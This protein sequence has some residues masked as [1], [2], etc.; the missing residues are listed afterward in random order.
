MEWVVESYCEIAMGTKADIV[1]NEAIAML[2]DTATRPDVIRLLA[3][4]RG[5]ECGR[6]SPMPEPDIMAGQCSL[7][8]RGEG[9]SVIIFRA[10]PARLGVDVLRFATAT[11]GVPLVSD[12]TLAEARLQLWRG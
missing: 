6:G 9:D 5:L 11:T 7:K 1:E 10:E 2:R 3:W 12:L 4:L 8:Y